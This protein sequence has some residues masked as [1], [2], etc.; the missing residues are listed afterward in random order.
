LVEFDVVYVCPL[1]ARL[2]LGGVAVAEYFGVNFHIVVS[3][4][5]GGGYEKK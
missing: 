5:F 1:E 4:F 3:V 2:P